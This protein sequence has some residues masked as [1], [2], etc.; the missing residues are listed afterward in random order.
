VLAAEGARVVMA[1]RSDEAVRREAE[2]VGRGA[3]GVAIDV[4]DP[5][6][7]ETAVKG[8]L[9]RHGGIDILV[10]NAGVTRDGLILRM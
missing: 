3:E 7:V 6:S 5:A 1:A 9:E 4:T 10:N 2:T 8:V